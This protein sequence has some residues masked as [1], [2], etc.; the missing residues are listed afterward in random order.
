MD[1]KG[2]AL[3]RARWQF[4]AYFDCNYD[5]FGFLTNAEGMTIMLVI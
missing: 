4:F 2:M 5:Q 1:T 3:A